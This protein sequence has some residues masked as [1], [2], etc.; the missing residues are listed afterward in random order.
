MTIP[1]LS[2]LFAFPFLIS[3]CD[4]YSD[5]MREP[6]PHETMT[7]HQ[8]RGYA[9]GTS[10]LIYNYHDTIKT[11]FSIPF[12]ELFLETYQIDRGVSFKDIV[13]HYK[14]SLKES[15]AW[16]PVDPA[17]LEWSDDTHAAGWKDNKKV[18]IV[19]AANP[20]RETDMMPVFTLSNLGRAKEQ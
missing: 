1:R 17:G 16:T 18:F 5:E 15:G 6:P 3:S 11:R 9:P 19:I 7:F 2:V 14:L 4:P 8:E 20:Q 12:G 10:A 13:L